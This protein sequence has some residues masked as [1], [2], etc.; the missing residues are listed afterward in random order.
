[1][2]S[3][4]QNFQLGTE[5]MTEEQLADYQANEPGTFITWHFLDEADPAG[6][7]L[8]DA[9]VTHPATNIASDAVFW[10]FFN[11]HGLV[12][13][14]TGDEWPLPDNV[15]THPR[16]AGTFAKILRSYVR[17]RGLMSMSTAIN[18]MSLM[19]AQVLEDFVPQMRQKGR[20]QV[21][22]DADIVVFDP[23]TISDQATY[24]NANQPAVGVQTLLVNGSFT[25]KD[26]DLVLDASSGQ[27]IRRAYSE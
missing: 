11:E 16:S 22:M 5:R 6:L 18:K 1:M 2:D 15:F 13:T 20:I 26:G 23:A 7:S 8:L 10:S 12:K 19:P 17:E 27:A 25:V 14:Y 9:S 21:G 24:E 3:T 4:A